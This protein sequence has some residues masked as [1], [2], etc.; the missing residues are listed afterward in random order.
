MTTLE[1]V[2]QGRFW[3]RKQELIEEL[4]DMGLDT[5]AECDEYMTVVQEGEN[6]EDVYYM[7]YLGHANSTIWVKRVECEEM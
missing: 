3:T 5:Y 4:E 1:L 2:L 7:I 6:S